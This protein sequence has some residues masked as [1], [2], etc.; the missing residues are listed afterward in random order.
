MGWKDEHRTARLLDDIEQTVRGARVSGRFDEHEIGVPRGGEGE[1]PVHR[2]AALQRHV[3][4]DGLGREG[5][6]QAVEL[7][8]Q[9][10]ELGTH[11]AA[12]LIDRVEQ[13]RT[14]ESRAHQ[15]GEPLPHPFGE[16]RRID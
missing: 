11:L 5:H 3:G 1:Q 12:C 2:I 9:P 16:V 7:G 15:V 8:P 13:G 6:R 10:F 14:A 4:L